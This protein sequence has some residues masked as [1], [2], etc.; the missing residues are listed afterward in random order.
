VAGMCRLLPM[1]YLRYTR[2]SDI[3]VDPHRALPAP[4]PMQHAIAPDGPLVG[5]SDPCRQERLGAERR[6][7]LDSDTFAYLHRKTPRRL[8]DMGLLQCKHASC[9][10]RESLGCSGGSCTQDGSSVKAVEAL[11]PLSNLGFAVRRGGGYGNRDN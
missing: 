9:E 10:D 6:P 1:H 7:G 3:R 11:G 2:Q 4:T 5:A 8:R